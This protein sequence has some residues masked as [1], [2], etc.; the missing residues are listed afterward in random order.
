MTQRV[1]CFPTSPNP[2]TTTENTAMNTATLP[3]VTTEN[4]FDAARGLYWFC[5]HWHGGQDTTLYSILSSRLD[6]HPG[7]GEDAPDPEDTTG[8]DW[9]ASEFYCAL[10]AI[11]AR[12]RDSAAE[13]LLEAIQ[14]AYDAAHD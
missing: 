3:S 2:F 4:Y 1:R 10:E 6:Y 8:E 9:E 12:D 7:M 14:A 11:P 13:S 5:C